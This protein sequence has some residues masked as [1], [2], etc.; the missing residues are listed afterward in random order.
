MLA[1]DAN[2]AKLIH[3]Q[4]TANSNPVYNSNPWHN[5]LN[6]FEQS[7]TMQTSLLLIC[8]VQENRKNENE[9]S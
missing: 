8:R 3:M 4:D 7:C 1:R 9:K 5:S 2:N 6:L